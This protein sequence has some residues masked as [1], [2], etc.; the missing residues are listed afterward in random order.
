VGSATQSVSIA[1]SLG[2]IWAA[3]EWTWLRGAW[4][5]TTDNPFLPYSWSVSLGHELNGGVLLTSQG[6]SHVIYVQ[7]R[8]MRG[9]VQTNSGAED[10]SGRWDRM[11]RLTGVTKR[12]CGHLSDGFSFLSGFSLATR[13]RMVRRGSTG[14]PS[15]QLE[16]IAWAPRAD[17]HL[18]AIAVAV[19]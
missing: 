4:A 13:G 5:V 17:R 2:T 19:P 18:A 7:N 15:G 9:N 1:H 11:H 16:T 14:Y 6:G 3:M 8:C 12:D 10:D